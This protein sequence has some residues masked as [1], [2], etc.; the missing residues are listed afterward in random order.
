MSLKKYQLVPFRDTKVED[1]KLKAILQPR[2]TPTS[3]VPVIDVLKN[4]ET[5]DVKVKQILESLRFMLRPPSSPPD[6]PIH[7]VKSRDQPSQTD[8]FDQNINVMVKY[9][10]KTYRQKA[11]T[12]LELLRPVLSWD[13]T[14]LHIIFN[15]KPLPDSNILDLTMYL[16]SKAKQVE[17]PAH[18][19]LLAPLLVAQNLPKNVVNYDRFKRSLAKAQSTIRRGSPESA[20]SPKRGRL[21]SASSPD[22]PPIRASKRLIEKGWLPF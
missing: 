22:S 19:E 12:L 7:E 4:A 5:D 9:L 16:I 6:E 15:N 21:P 8:E 2:P 13:A 17:V 14:T 3:E 20:P 10:G 18:F 1:A 11:R